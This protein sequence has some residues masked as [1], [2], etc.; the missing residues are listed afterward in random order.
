M[1]GRKKKPGKPRTHDLTVGALWLRGKH[2][3]YAH[4]DWEKAKVLFDRPIPRRDTGKAIPV[5][6]I[7]QVLATVGAIGMIFLFPGAGAVIGS[8]VLGNREYSPWQTRRVIDR[9]KKQKYISVEYLEEGKVKVKITKNGRVKALSYQLEEMELKIPKKW[10]GKWRVVIFDI[11]EKYKRVR[12]LF[13]MRLVQL[14]L[15]QMQESVYISPYPCF[16]EI[17]FL[18]ELYGISFTVEYL[19]VERV[20]DDS[21]IKIHFD[22]A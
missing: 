4:I 2:S 13:R 10:D 8:L 6:D 1:L 14:G 7:L 18:R 20:E 11:P 3:P 16:D 9:L 12:D 15:Y 5:R 19:L 21:K 22:L 17:E